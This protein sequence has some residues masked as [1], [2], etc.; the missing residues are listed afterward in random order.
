MQ[1][2][3]IDRQR[4]EPFLLQGAA[5]A[6]DQQGGADLDDDAVELIE[7]EKRFQGRARL[8]EG[9]EA[10]RRPSNWGAA[11]RGCIGG[12]A[13]NFA[14]IVRPSGT[15]S[16]VFPRR[17]TARARR[18]R[19]RTGSCSATASC[20]R[21]NLESKRFQTF[22]NFAESTISMAYILQ[23]FGFQ[24]FSKFFFGRNAGYQGATDEKIWKQLFFEN[25]TR[26]AA[27]FPLAAFRR[28]PFAPSIRNRARTRASLRSRNCE[29][30]S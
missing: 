25:S 18:A 10:G 21:E 6:I 7:R 28:S 19:R 8:D 22:A 15:M 3:Q 12:N 5:S 14:P 2:G 30:G 29:T 26:T 23:K 11:A 16:G 20:R 17:R 27:Q 1:R 24:A 4:I 13:T 9:G